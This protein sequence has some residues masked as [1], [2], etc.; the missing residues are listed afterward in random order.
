M[1]SEDV[2]HLPVRKE[3]VA[4]KTDWLIHSPRAHAA[5]YRSAD[6]KEII[7]SNGLVSRTFR[8]TPNAATVALDNLT[9][10]DSML[11]A[12]KPEATLDLDGARY[13]VGGLVGQP[14]LAYLKPEW[15][16]AM[17][18]DPSAFQFT[19]FTTGKTAARF[20]WKHARH[21]ADLPW[22]PPGAALTLHFRP[23]AGK[24]PGISVDVHY[25][26]YDGIPLLSKWLTIRNDGAKP[27]RLDKFS[28][29][30]LGLVEAESIVDNADHWQLPNITVV[31]DYTFGG[32]QSRTTFWVPDPDYTT[33]VNYTLQTPCVLECRPPLGPAID[34]A[35][36]TLQ[37]TF[38]TFELLHDTAERERKGL[39]IRR[40]YRALAPWAT[41]NPLM[42]HLTSVDP[43]IAYTA[44][45]QC[46]DVGFEMVILS[47]GSGLN[48][49]DVAPQNIA[50]FKALADYAH[51]KGIEIGGY[52]LLASR[53]IDDADDV[54]NPKTG[55]PGGAVFGDSP[56]LGSRWGIDYFHHLRT[57]LEQT[58]FSLLENDGSYPSDVCAS[59]QHP[60]HR[61]LE[62]SQWQQ[63]QQIAEFYSWCRSHGIYLNVP[64][65]Y[66][67]VGSNKTGMG[68]RET[69]WSLPRE[70]QHI[71][72]RQNLFDGTW[73][74]APTMG[75]MFVPLV[76]Y[77]GGGAAATIEPLSE[78]LPDYE[79]HLA[80]NLGFGAQA[81]YRGPRLYDTEATRTLVK[82]WVT[83]FKA[84]RAILESD[85]IHLRR[86]D[87]RDLDG[88]LHV[89]PYL[90]EKGLAV[91]YN[92]T[93]QPITR[94]LDLPLYYTGLAD[95]AQI[96]IED[97]PAQTYTLD[98]AYHAHVKV[99]IK[100]GG[101]TWLTIKQ[102]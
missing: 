64:D 75:W 57:F 63:Y 71:H 29:E 54:I 80:N 53:H 17:H 33:Q 85:I 88:I 100:P 30:I 22:P 68:Y 1:A 79:L 3:Q 38:R 90:L 74:K 16:D 45:D 12:V 40:M 92:P 58:G 50:R 99:T 96:R 82:K 69:N 55:K 4:E 59:T 18:A 28:S 27:V 78:H 102:G 72:A 42:L 36:G 93:Q 7:L 39:E 49:E 35:P 31:S 65:W 87:A 89:N 94:E 15:L 26:L 95:K 81:C 2:S 83:W 67:L 97:G 77:Q 41:E 14:E 8:L 11:R 56:C 86:A 10:G 43:K 6:D 9:T 66:F 76:E 5:I 52:S 37:D 73:Q 101:I 32:H 21:C 51:S 23:P 60:G 61:G 62:D 91:F 84:H 48:M 20:A 46:A 24:L 47:F 13:D 98:R 44:I 25:E 19:G 70:Q 34:I